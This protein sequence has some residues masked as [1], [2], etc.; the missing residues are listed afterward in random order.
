VFP[1]FKYWALDAYSFEYAV[2]PCRTLCC[3][4]VFCTEHLADVRI[5]SLVLTPGFWIL[6]IV[7]TWT[8][9][10]RAMS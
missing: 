5:L 10:R 1:D 3:G 4:K 7:A 8:W 2:L 6:L 9:S